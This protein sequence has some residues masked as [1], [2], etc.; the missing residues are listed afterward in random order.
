MAQIYCSLGP[1]LYA[2]LRPILG[3]ALAQAGSQYWQ[4]ILENLHWPKLGIIL[5]DDIVWLYWHDL[6]PRLACQCCLYWLAL[7]WQTTSCQSWRAK[8]RPMLGQ[9]KFTWFVNEKQSWP[10]IGLI[11]A[12]QDWR[13]NGLPTYCFIGP[14]LYAKLGLVLGCALAQS[15]SQ[16][17]QPIMGDILCPCLAVYWQMIVCAWYKYVQRLKWWISCIYYNF[18][19]IAKSNTYPSLSINLWQFKML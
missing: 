5:A 17:W 18:L 19:V 10:N 9:D 2:K 1:I 16:Y 13:A 12:C 14:I 3:C 6:G 15:G 8:I 7:A 4:P 11:L